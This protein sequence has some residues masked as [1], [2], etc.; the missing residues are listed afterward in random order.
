MT[1]QPSP[2]DYYRLGEIRAH[3]KKYDAAIEA[4]N[5]AIELDNGMGIKAYAEQAIAAVQKA[6]GAGPAKP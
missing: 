5:H 6:K 3:L 1:G 2:T 4:Y